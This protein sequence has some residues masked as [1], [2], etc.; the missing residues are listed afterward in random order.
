MS[1]TRQ[2]LTP[3]ILLAYLSCTPATVPDHPESAEQTMD[4]LNDRGDS[5]R[6]AANYPEAMRT[7]MQLMDSAL[8][9]ADSF[10]YYDARLDLAATHERTGEFDKA[11]VLAEE[12]V[13]AYHRSGDTL[14]VGRGYNT[15][16]GFYM[17]AKRPDE[18]L[19]T[20]KKGFE[21]LRN[22]P[23]PPHRCA[24]YNQM[25]FTYSDAGDWARA[26]PL[27]DTALQIIRT[28]E[29]PD[30]LAGILLNNGD[31]RRQLGQWAEAKDLLQE[32]L[33]VADTL[34]QI[35]I[36]ARVLERLSQIAEAE[37]QPDE[38]LSYYKHAKTIRDSLFTREKNRNLQELTVEYETLEKE[39]ALQ[40]LQMQTKID[41]VWKFGAAIVIVLL[42]ALF[43]VVF[44]KQKEKR[45]RDNMELLQHRQNLQ[46]ISQLLRSKNAHISELEARLGNLPEETSE[47][48]E[49]TADLH[50]SWY[51]LRI[52][53][54]N[55]WQ[56]F[57]S[58]FEKSYPN[59]L[60]NVRQKHPELSS[61][62]E[63]LLLLLKLN[64]NR[65]EVAST[66]GISPESVKKARQ[67]LRKRLNLDKDENLEL[68]VRSME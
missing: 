7:Y 33:L 52:L 30:L 42:V 10:A 15:L 19:S 40:Q 63:R 16:G 56:F 68:Y 39:K 1:T 61:A 65:Q 51:N 46:D 32:A 6:S 44:L 43:S 49:D 48:T 66:L 17:R 59:F 35:H 25:A 18:A 9:H 55:D 8:L 50:E 37:K 38:A 62:E 11:I 20:L 28:F 2:L 54:E 34:H 36:K 21:I 5:L 3:C 64:F 27:L 57:K 29:E 12:V 53:T 4:A 14:R 47:A 58:F 41:A 23:S 13:A 22:H 67:R 24:A 45:R 26:M 31:C 60:Y